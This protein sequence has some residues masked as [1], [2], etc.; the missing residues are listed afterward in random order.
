MAHRLESCSIENIRW[1][2]DCRS[3]V[4]LNR[5][6]EVFQRLGAP[7]E[8]PNFGTAGGEPSSES[9]ANA[10]A[11]SSDE[12]DTILE[13][14]QAVQIGFARVHSAPNSEWSAAGRAAVVPL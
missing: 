11:S 9:V 7:S 5:A 4:Q 10:S 13:A 8:E 3:A 2:R 6:R 14:E 1:E 12:G